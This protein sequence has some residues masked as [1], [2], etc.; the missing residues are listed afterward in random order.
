MAFKV[1]S[2]AEKMRDITMAKIENEF[3]EFDKVMSNEKFLEILNKIEQAANKG[4]SDIEVFLYNYPDEEERNR[5]SGLARMF[6]MCLF[7]EKFGYRVRVV[8]GETYYPDAAFVF[9]RHY[10]YIKLVISW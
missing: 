10:Y 8:K 9:E 5:R 7:S 2:H 1:Q 3:G 4:E 6:S